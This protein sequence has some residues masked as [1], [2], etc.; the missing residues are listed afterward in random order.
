MCRLGQD[1][2]RSHSEFHLLSLWRLRELRLHDQIF[3]FWWVSFHPHFTQN[4]SQTRFTTVTV[5][6]SLAWDI[7]YEV[8]RSSP[9]WWI[10][11]SPQM[12][13][14]KFLVLHLWPPGLLCRDACCD[15]LFQSLPCDLQPE[16]LPLI[17]SWA[18]RTLSRPSF[19]IPFEPESP[20][21]G[22]HVTI[23]IEFSF[24]RQNPRLTLLTMV[25]CT[26]MSGATLISS[27]MMA[28]LSSSNLRSLAS[29]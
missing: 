6:S 13:V 22:S 16:F 2:D 14:L 28:S 24:L 8:S 3:L 4:N 26:Q 23:A 18:C 17:P 25:L 9:V 29:H 27:Q 1:M 11:F 15:R 20:I 19:P 21:A 7:K 5:W 12:Q 10:F